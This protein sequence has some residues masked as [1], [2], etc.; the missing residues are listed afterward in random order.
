MFY[1]KFL[2]IF[3]I[4]ENLWKSCEI[5]VEILGG[6]K[7]CKLEFRKVAANTRQI[8]HFWEIWGRQ[9]MLY[10]KPEFGEIDANTE[11][12]VHFWANAMP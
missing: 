11:Q 5:F 1:V 6:F 8:V 10:A 4:S 12:I 2:R 3:Y 9:T 7:L